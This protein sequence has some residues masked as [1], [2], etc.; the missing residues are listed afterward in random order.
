MSPEKR[1]AVMARIRGKDTGPERA[2][3]EA[4]AARGWGFE[5]HASDLPGRPDILFRA[6]MLAVFV[7]GDFWHGWRFPVWRDKL[8]A[9]WEAKIESNRRR[10]AKNFRKLRR[11]GWSVVR[12]WEHQVK[13]DLHG[14]IAR[15]ES[16]L[17]GKVRQRR[18]LP[19]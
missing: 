4:L 13:R 11:S 2:V 18:I 8:S 9:T 10:D 17:P 5:T 12:L 3:A 1:S 6:P 15:V 19:K 14:C 7:D 16:L